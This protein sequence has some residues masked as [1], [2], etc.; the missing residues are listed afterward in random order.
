MSQDSGG[1]SQLS[2][3]PSQTD[4][5]HPTTLNTE[6]R[7]SSKADDI[8]HYGGSFVSSSSSGGGDPVHRW[9]SGGTGPVNGGSPN[10][11]G[12]HHIRHASSQEF[13]RPHHPSVHSSMKFATSPR[14]GSLPYPP[15]LKTLN[16]NPQESGLYSFSGPASHLAKLSNSQTLG[17]SRTHI[18]LHVATAMGGRR[19]SLPMNNPRSGSRGPFV[20]PHQV[21]GGGL[22]NS[23]LSQPFQPLAPNACIEQDVPPLSADMSTG[24]STDNGMPLT[25]VD[26]LFMSAAANHDSMG[27]NMAPPAGQAL[28]GPLPNPDYSFGLQ[29]TCQVGGADGASTHHSLATHPF[30]HPSPYPYRD[31]LGSMA[32]V[33]SQASQVSTEASG[34]GGAPSGDWGDTAT[35]PGYPSVFPWPPNE[36]EALMMQGNGGG[37]ASDADGTRLTLPLGFASDARR[38]SA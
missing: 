24:F 32:S 23:L 38:A 7:A 20:R 10:G 30:V 8:Q 26:P 29:G 9:G 31:R 13:V 36:K 17:P 27:L 35:L 2:S 11:A 5:N 12:V 18:P 19:A 4:Q 34:G 6:R 1:D 15:P 16:E 37:G 14:R 28:P 22:Q 25:G 3:F 21:N 33:F